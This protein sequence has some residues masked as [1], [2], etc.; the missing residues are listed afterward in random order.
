MKMI[1]TS[2][3]LAGAALG[4][5]LAASSASAQPPPSEEPPPGEGPAAPVRRPLGFFE[6]AGNYGISF[7]EQEFVP[8]GTQ[9]DRENPLTNGFGVNA[10]AGYTLTPG[11]DI[12]AD[13]N[14]ANAKSRVGEITGVLDEVHGSIHYHTLTAGVRTSLGI[15]P[16]RVYGELAGGIV[17]PFHTT[18]TFEYAAPMSELGITGTGTEVRNFNLGYGAHGEAGYQFTITPRAYV[19]T[20]VRVQSFQ[21]S[22]AGKTTEFDNFVTDFAAP[23]PITMEV[24]HATNTAEAPV[25]YSVQ[26]VRFFLDLG[27]RF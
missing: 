13:Y 18:L 15:G 7:G 20:A 19:A 12:I 26:D 27:Y 25:T 4:L 6:V 22:N 11:F 24:N 17:F 5:C 16:G 3:G 9:T 10:T 23:A 14:F 21:S 1:N 2:I 8:E